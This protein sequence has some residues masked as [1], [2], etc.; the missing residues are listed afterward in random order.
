MDDRYLVRERD[1]SSYRAAAG[2]EPE[3]FDREVEDVDVYVAIGQGMK[4]IKARKRPIHESPFPH[5][6]KVRKGLLTERGA[7]G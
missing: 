6:G 1:G 7:A 5:R 2:V 4:E 3:L